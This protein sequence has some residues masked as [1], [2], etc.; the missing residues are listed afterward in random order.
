MTM[1][2]SAH[3]NPK[4]WTAISVKPNQGDK[5][6]RN[7]EQQGF[8]YFAPKIKLTQR[9]NNRFV[10]KIKL[11]FPGYMFV[12]IATNGEDVRKIN[13][14]I[15]V[16]NIIK[17]GGQIGAI[18]DAFIDDLQ[19]R[20][21]DDVIFSDNDLTPGQKVEVIKG[22]FVGLIA[23]LARVDSTKR[24]QCLFDLISGKVYGYITTEDFVLAT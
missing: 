2:C 18:P 20:V 15:G 8:C 1:S 9:S 16:S 3:K 4:I 13:S 14:T 10:K 11:M 19:A 7:L 12:R 6:E 23:E 5:A 22:P 21:D 17:T 24:V